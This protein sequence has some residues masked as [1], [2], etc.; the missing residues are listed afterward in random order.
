[1]NQI[2]NNIRYILYVRK[3]TDDVDRQL[4]SLESQTN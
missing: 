3:S 1:M 4:L 2:E